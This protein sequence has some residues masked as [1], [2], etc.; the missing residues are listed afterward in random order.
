[1]KQSS[2]GT[3]LKKRILNFE[4][5][6]EVGSGTRSIIDH[7]SADA[8]PAQLIMREDPDHPDNLDHNDDGDVT[9]SHA[10]CEDWPRIRHNATP[11]CSNPT[12]LLTASLNAPPQSYSSGG[13]VRVKAVSDLHLPPIKKRGDES[14]RGEASSPGG[15][16]QSPADFYSTLLKQLRQKVGEG[17]HVAVLARPKKEKTVRPL[18]FMCPA[19]KKRFQRHIAMNAHFQNE[20]LSPAGANGE[21]TCRL[22]GSS[23]P[24][25]LAV[26]HHLKT[27]HNIDLDSSTKC[28]EEGSTYS[29]KYSVLEA[30]LRSGQPGE[31]SEPSCS[32]IDMSETSQSP[33]S[34]S[35]GHTPSSSQSPERCLFP[36]K[37]ETAKQDQPRQGAQ[38]D[39]DLQ[40]EDLS[41]R[42][43]SPASPV[44]PRARF[45]PAPRS[46]RP[47]SPSAKLSN[48]RPRVCEASPPPPCSSQT[49]ARAPAPASPRFTCN[50]CHIVYPNQTLYF[51]HRGFHSDSNPWRCNGCGHVSTD[52]YDFNSHLFSVAHR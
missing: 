22:C 15:V 34:N 31:E 28:L 23:S 3:T 27:A 5:I 30:S 50:H 44:P 16:P 39:D 42:R 24:S 38:D 17:P 8:R 47:E 40:V 12:P 19:C 4:N 9:N 29:Q 46:P 26:R 49:S 18:P 48:K 36:I 25:L 14:G 51:L 6:R 13:S 2:G 7:Q 52:L 33:P 10:P 45:S 41:I 20:H 35:P 43:P 37:Q 21:R 11:P 32:N 1:M